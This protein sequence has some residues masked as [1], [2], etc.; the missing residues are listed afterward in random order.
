MA[1][2]SPRRVTAYHHASD[3]PEECW[4]ALR[5][6]E[7]A[8]NII[9][10]FAIKARHFPREDGK[11][12]LWI[13]VY[14]D[15]GKDVEFVLSCTKG[16]LENY[17]VF[18][19]THKSAAQLAQDEQQ[20][21][22][23]LLQLVLCLLN[24]VPPQRVFSVFSLSQVA[25]KFAEI[26]QEHAQGHGI[27]ALEAPYYDASLAVC[28]KETLNKSS[29]SFSSFPDDF[30][31]ALRRADISDL[32]GTKALCKGFSLTSVSIAY[33]AWEINS[34]VFCANSRLMN[35]TMKVQ[36]WRLER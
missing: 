20:M 17:P 14:D 23:A 31:I 33:I 12:Q 24:E 5:Q 18:V 22:D 29:A 16:A 28:T 4:I 10:P 30:S 32:E 19:Y 6:N 26:F 2:I 7:L 13:I 8:A 35:W 11:D 3:L 36:S 34:D 1:S 25:L 21:A 15:T 9:L 27:Q